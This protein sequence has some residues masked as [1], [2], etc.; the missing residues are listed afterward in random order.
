MI[1]GDIVAGS[2]VY[3]K[4]TNRADHPAAQLVPRLE[5]KPPQQTVPGLFI[6]E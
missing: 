3:V 5:E 2:L 4:V 6:E 1:R